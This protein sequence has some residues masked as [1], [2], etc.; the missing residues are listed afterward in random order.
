MEWE[1]ERDLAVDNYRALTKDT[2]RVCTVLQGKETESGSHYAVRFDDAKGIF[3][4]YFTDLV[5]L[6][7]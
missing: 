4:Y 7:R 3:F 5:L 2:G 1:R 6:G